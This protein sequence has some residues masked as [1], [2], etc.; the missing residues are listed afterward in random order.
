MNTVLFAVLAPVM[1]NRAVLASGSSSA[2][3]LSTFFNL[4]TSALTW[5]ITSFGTILN[6][7]LANPICF[8]WLVFS[9]IGTAF[10][11]LRSTIGG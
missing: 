11:F 3:D 1:M 7:M 9:I 5:L 2:A 4:A 10:V 8:V 6:F